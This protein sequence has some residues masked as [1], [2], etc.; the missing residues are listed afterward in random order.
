M[1]IFIWEA[2]VNMGMIG[3]AIQTPLRKINLITKRPCR[4]L[5]REKKKKPPQSI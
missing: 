4:Q 3:P 5:K 1:I 2:I